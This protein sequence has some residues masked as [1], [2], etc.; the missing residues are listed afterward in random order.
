V[1][2]GFLE[3]VRPTLVN[4]RVIELVLMIEFFL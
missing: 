1:R 4:A 3:Q 2:P